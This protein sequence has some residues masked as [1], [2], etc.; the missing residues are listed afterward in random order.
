MTIVQ[1]K[2]MSMTNDKNDLVSVLV[3]WK[4]VAHTNLML[5]PTTNNKNSLSG[6][7][8]GCC[9]NNKK[10]AKISKIPKFHFTSKSHHSSTHTSKSH[11]KAP[12]ILPHKQLS[13]TTATTTSSHTHFAFEITHVRQGFPHIQK[14]YS[15]FVR[16]KI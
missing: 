5:M 16:A 7:T 10:I 15:I 11:S 6:L 13:Q 3:N 9:H 4:M 2:S 14:P 8:G 1:M 12:T